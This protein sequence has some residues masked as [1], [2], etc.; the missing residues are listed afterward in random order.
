MERHS[1]DGD[2]TERN[3]SVATKATFY[4]RLASRLRLF[5]R[6]SFPGRDVHHEFLDV[7]AA[8]VG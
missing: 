6:R 8:Q 3:G 1:I 7:G 2:T 5:D 4:H